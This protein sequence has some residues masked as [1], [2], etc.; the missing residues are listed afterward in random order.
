MI[1]RKKYPDLIIDLIK[2]KPTLKR[3]K[4]WIDISNIGKSRVLKLAPIIMLIIP[5]CVEILSRL[6]TKAIIFYIRDQ[7]IVISL[8]LPFS[9]EI[10]FLSSFSATISWFLYNTFCPSIVKKY[11]SVSQFEAEGR[12]PR[13]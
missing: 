11:N 13:N 8:T 9:W 2:Y 4:G 5:I 7:E 6:D 1:F 3:T 10:L 12:G